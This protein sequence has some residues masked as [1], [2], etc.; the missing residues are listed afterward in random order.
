MNIV[1]Y[2]SVNSKPHEAWLAYIV[3][4]T[5]EQWLV[6][7]VG[8]TEEEAKTRAQAL[9]EK[10]QARYATVNAMCEPS[11]G[12]GH[13]FAGKVWVIN[14]ETHDLRR[15]ALSELASYEAQGYVRG[16]PRSRMGLLS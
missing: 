6:R 10:E 13:H 15:I 9:W 16:G 4:S 11:E 12:R 2:H 14:R 3:L 1:T 8:H 5:G 7:C